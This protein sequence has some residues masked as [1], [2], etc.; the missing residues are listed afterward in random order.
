VA[1]SHDTAILTAFSGGKGGDG[2]PANRF[3]SPYPCG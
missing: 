2:D 3:A 1:S